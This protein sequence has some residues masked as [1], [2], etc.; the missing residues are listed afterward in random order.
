[1]GV[2]GERVHIYFVVVFRWIGGRGAGRGN[3][4]V[5]GERVHICSDNSGK[6]T[7]EAGIVWVF[8]VVV[9]WF[10][11]CFCFAFPPY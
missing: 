9:F 1:M 6:N 8:V 11:C 3:V 2:G 10:C 5:G 7:A 4:G